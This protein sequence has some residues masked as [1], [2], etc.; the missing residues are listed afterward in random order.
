[1]NT[2]EAPALDDEARACW[3]TSRKSRFKICGKL[4]IDWVNSTMW[5][6][7][8]RPIGRGKW[9]MIL[10]A[11][12][13]QQNSWDIPRSNT[14]SQWGHGGISAHWRLLYAMSSLKSLISG[15]G[16]W[17]KYPD[18]RSRRQTWRISRWLSEP[19]FCLVISY[20]A[21]NAILDFPVSNEL[22][23]N[24]TKVGALRMCFTGEIGW[25]SQNEKLVIF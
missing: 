25:H 8:Y 9:F 15:K 18:D 6:S 3:R 24:A 13:L 11:K 2:F 14:A 4:G 12:G 16:K 23:K 21:V 22:W 20:F 5:S 7:N 10:P 1:M 17:S 19:F